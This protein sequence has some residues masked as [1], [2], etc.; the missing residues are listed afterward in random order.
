MS[1]TDET[2]SIQKEE[3]KTTLKIRNERDVT[4]SS[5]EAQVFLKLL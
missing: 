5:T 1:K 3:I 2:S 4:N